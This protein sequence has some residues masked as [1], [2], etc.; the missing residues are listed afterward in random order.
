MSRFLLVICFLYFVSDALVR[1]RIISC[2]FHV[3]VLSQYLLRRDFFLGHVRSFGFLQRF[4][5]CSLVLFFSTLPG[6]CL[7]DNFVLFD[8]DFRLSR[9]FHH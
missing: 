3:P 5:F 8:K 4:F 9:F 2:Q 7:K 1:G 6:L